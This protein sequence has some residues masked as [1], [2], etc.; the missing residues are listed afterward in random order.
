[1]GLLHVMAMGIVL[2]TTMHVFVKKIMILLLNAEVVQAV[3][4][5]TPTALVILK[6]TLWSRDLVHKKAEP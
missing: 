1:M 6:I 3:I 2:S 4:M 5:G